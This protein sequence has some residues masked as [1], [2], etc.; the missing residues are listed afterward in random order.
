M[1]SLKTTCWGSSQS[2]WSHTPTD[3]CHRSMSLAHIQPL[4]AHFPVE[5]CSEVSGLPGRSHPQN[6][7]WWKQVGGEGRGTRARGRVCLQQGS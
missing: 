2:S 1:K 7:N 6:A 4:R 5:R 3:Q